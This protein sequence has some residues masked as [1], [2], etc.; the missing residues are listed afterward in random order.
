MFIQSSANQLLTPRVR[1]RF[2]NKTYFQGDLVRKL[3]QTS[4]K[5]IDQEGFFPL[6]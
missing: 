2:A 3:I 6:S 1:K 5:Q 4:K